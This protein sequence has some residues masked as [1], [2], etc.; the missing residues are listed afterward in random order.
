M[1]GKSFREELK[2]EPKLG[3]LEALKNVGLDASLLVNDMIIL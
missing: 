2:V 3:I 1:L